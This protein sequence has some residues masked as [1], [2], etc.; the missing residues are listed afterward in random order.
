MSKYL[1]SVAVT[2]F[3]SEVKQAYQGGGYLRNTVTT[4]MNVTGDTYKFRKMGKGIATLKNGHASSVTPMDIE[5]ALKTVT[6]ANYNA[7][8]YTDIFDQAEVNFEEKVELAQCIAN[9]LG[10][11]DDQIIIS[12]LGAVTY[13]ATP[14]DSQ[15]YQIAAGGSQLTAAKLRE[16]ATAL[17]GR[18]VR[19]KEMYVIHTAEDLQN[20]LGESTITSSD[21]ANVKALVNGEIDTFMGFKFI[22]IE[23]R[24]EGGLPS[25]KAYAYAKSAVGYA[26]A[27]EKKTEI[28]YVPER[29]SWLVTGWLKSGAVV[30]D[31]AGCVEINM[32]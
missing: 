24:A 4:R 27:L 21:Y 31:E 9:A 29:G 30:R 23:T 5:H 10:R 15:G 19:D 11:R 28:N 26:C 13:S 25:N 6:L 8:E 1:S 16:A 3:D 12:A 22:L 7:A 18:G 17:K 2:D 14:T 32:A 20:M